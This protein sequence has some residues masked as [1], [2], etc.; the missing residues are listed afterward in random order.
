MPGR[1]VL[2]DTSFLVA[3][4]NK[5]DRHHERAKALVRELFKEDAVLVLHWG[6]LLEIA[7]GFARVGRRARGLE[8]LGK[9]LGESGYHMHPI[10]VPLL[11]E[12]LDIYRARPDVNC[13]VH[14]HP[15]HAAALAMLEIPLQV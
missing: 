15:L 4:E 14:T 7:D 10:T 6:V 2:L 11:Q 1:P 8:L 5:D 9:F 3:L 12:G 13:I